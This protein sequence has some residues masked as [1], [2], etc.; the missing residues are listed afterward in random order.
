[1]DEAL[2][3]VGMYEFREKAPHKLSGGQK[4]R[5]AVAGIIAMRPQCIVLDELQLCLTQAA[6]RK[7]WKP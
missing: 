5:V 7:L 3:T 2:K 1:M 4:Q 6:E